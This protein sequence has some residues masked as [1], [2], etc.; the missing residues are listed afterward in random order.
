MSGIG[1]LTMRTAPWMVPLLA[2]GIFSIDLLTPAGVAVSMSIRRSVTATSTSDRPMAPL[3][4][5]G[6]ATV[7]AW[8]DALMKPSGLPIP[9]AIFN[10]A[11]G[12]MVLWGIAVGLIMLQ[13]G[14]T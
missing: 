8:T 12:T 10:R 3:Y 4:F 6:V 9:Y 11:F 2:F 5:C 1:R 7:L 14:S 13:T